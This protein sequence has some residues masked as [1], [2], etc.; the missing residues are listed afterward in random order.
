M[1]F[2]LP[3]LRRMSVPSTFHTRPTFPLFSLFL[4]FPHI[5]NSTIPLPVISS[6]H[7]PTPP[8]PPSLPAPTHPSISSVDVRLHRRRRLLLP[9]HPLN[10]R[11]CFPSPPLLPLPSRTQLN[12]HRDQAS[13]PTFHALRTSDEQSILL[14]RIARVLA[15]LLHS[16]R[17]EGDS[18]G[19]GSLG[20][21]GW[22]AGLV[23]RREL[24]E[25]K[26]EGPFDR[27]TR[28]GGER[29]GVRCCRR[30]RGDKLTGGDAT[31]AF[32]RLVGWLS[33]VGTGTEESPSQDEESFRC[34]SRERGVGV[35][36]TGLQGGR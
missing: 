11:P 9:T 15:R 28:E 12:S 32:G 17:T 1:S 10:T 7:H 19:S 8:S 16:D 33:G 29:N 30:I 18:V 31:R 22:V 14:R 24:G 21:V 3:R 2:P 36:M 13:I 35:W 4:S 23:G 34:G 26:L 25:G 27:G 20:R 6:S 5:S